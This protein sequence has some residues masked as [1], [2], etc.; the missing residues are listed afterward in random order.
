MAGKTLMVR[1]KNAETGEYLYAGSDD[2]VR[3]RQRRKVFTWREKNDGVAD[4]ADWKMSRIFTKGT[5]RVRF[6]YRVY[7]ETTEDY[8]EEPL[9]ISSESKYLYDCERRHVYTWRKG[10]AL[11]DGSADWYLENENY[12]ETKNRYAILNAKFKEHLYADSDDFAKD[13]SRRRIFTWVGD[14]NGD[15]LFTENDKKLAWDI[16]IAG[17]GQPVNVWQDGSHGAKWQFNCDFSGHD[18]GKVDASGENCGLECVNNPNCSHFSHHHDV[19]Y[20]K[21]ADISHNRH[22]A[23]GGMCGY[24]PDRT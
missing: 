8:T 5:Y 7:S 2:L 20:L 16:E 21:K 10:S 13:E 1:L 19:C 18:I 22:D 12:P 14:Q 9:F 23:D 6:S 11:T 24:L 15:Q 4:W 3:D 17:E